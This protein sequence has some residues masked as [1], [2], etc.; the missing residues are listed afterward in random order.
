MILDGVK[1][2]LGITGTGQDATL[3]VYIDEV[4]E[5]LKDA[6][7]PK[8]MLESPKAIG[9]IARGVADL[10]TYNGGDA[11]FSEYFLMRAN[12]LRVVEEA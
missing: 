10:W 8:F 2:A 3:Q 7:V 4:C 5:F 1:N 12:Q 11:E 6:G 9:V